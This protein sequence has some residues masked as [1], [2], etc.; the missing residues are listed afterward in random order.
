MSESIN[1]ELVDHRL[2]SNERL[3]IDVSKVEPVMVPQNAEA[4]FGVREYAV[5]T[6][7][8]GGHLFG[9]FDT[10][11]SDEY[12]TPFVLVDAKKHHQAAGVS[13]YKGI[14]PSTEPLDVGREYLI[15]RFSYLPTVSGKHFSIHYDNDSAISIQNHRPTNPT[16]IVIMSSEDDN[17]SREQHR[18][19]QALFTAG[20]RDYA[21]TDNYSSAATT[22]PYGHFRGHPII[23]RQSNSVKQGVYF[24]GNSEVLLVDDESKVMR[25]A[26]KKL[27][28]QV[29]QRAAGDETLFTRSI[30]LEAN[31]YVGHLMK[32]DLSATDK[33]CDPHYDK[34]QLVPLS[35]FIKRGI[36]VCRQQCL[37][38]ASVLEDLIESGMLPPG[39][40]GVER[41]HDLAVDGAHAWATYKPDSADADA[42]YIVDPA[43]KFVGFRKETTHEGWR[44]Y[45]P[46]D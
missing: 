35:T 36:G 25:R 17:K 41:N 3:A 7:N 45:L 16:S 19:L 42:T 6:I 29:K 44:Y 5:M 34:K 39:R 43:Q 2:G 33:I 14:W 18:D 37:F 26:S 15:D 23:G 22:A 12:M 8:A 46:V 38:A 20:A 1:A 32:Y 40:V 4:I 24:T 21:D 30:L 13:G 10:K 28:D 27:V 9:I 11:D 31:A